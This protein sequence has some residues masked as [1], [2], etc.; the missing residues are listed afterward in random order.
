[1]SIAPLWQPKDWRSELRDS[2]VA[3][4]E[5]WVDERYSFLSKVIADVCESPIEEMMLAALVIELG[6]DHV[7]AEHCILGRRGAPCELDQFLFE[8]Q[9]NADMAPQVTTEYVVCIGPQI[10]LGAYRV[11]FLIWV[12]HMFADPHR[13]MMIVVEC[14]GH[15]FHER[16]KEQAQRDKSRDRAIQAGGYKVFRFTGSEIFRNPFAGAQ[17]VEKII[18]RW[19]AED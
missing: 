8:C 19:L 15:D 5:S 4:A 11:D 17:E 13:E 14:D 2:L 7:R 18:S 12:R 6:I 10:K 16:T 3:E 1:M 9:A